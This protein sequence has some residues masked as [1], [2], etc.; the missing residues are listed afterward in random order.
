[1]RRLAAILA[2]GLLACNVQA[3]DSTF[4][5]NGYTYYVW[6]NTVSTN[7]TPTNTTYA[8]IL[9]VAGGG[10]AGSRVASTGGGGAGGVRWTNFSITAGSNYSVTV[11]SGGAGGGADAVARGSNGAA[12]VFGQV[13]STGGGGGG[14]ATATSP[15]FNGQNGGSG[16]GGAAPSGDA[17]SSPGSGSAGQG[18]DG[19]GK[20]FISVDERSGGGGGGAG[21]RGG[22]G[23]RNTPGAGG[24]GLNYSAWL[25]FANLGSNGVFAAGGRGGYY[26][27]N[28]LAVVHGAPGTGNGGLGTANDEAANTRAGGN[29]GSGIVIVKAFPPGAARQLSPGYPTLASVTNST[30]PLTWLAPAEGPTPSNYLVRVGASATNLPLIATTT[31]LTYTLDLLNQSTY[32]QMYWRIDAQA[33]GVTTTGTLASFVDAYQVAS[34]PTK[35]VDKTN[36]TARSPYTSWAAAATSLTQAFGVAESGDTIVVGPGTYGE[37]GGPS[38]SNRYTIPSNLTV[39]SRDGPA[40]TR[41]HGRIYIRPVTT[42]YLA[43]FRFEGIDNSEFRYGIL[44]CNN[45]SSALVV[46]NCWFIANTN[47]ANENGVLIGAIHI[48]ISVTHC[49]SSRNISS[50][51]AS[52]IYSRV[53]ARNCI[54]F[55][56][57]SVI[58]SFSTASNCT[59]VGASASAF[60]STAASASLSIYAGSAANNT[61]T[62][63]MIR[64]AAY[65]TAIG[66]TTNMT[67]TNFPAVPYFSAYDNFD[68]FRPLGNSIIR[69]DGLGALPYKPV[70]TSRTAHRIRTGGTQ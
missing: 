20:S 35:Y 5:T 64:A 63:P 41:I 57:G 17:A 68:A 26:T 67:G 29:G 38:G 44:T 9:V 55:G 42:N 19:G 51:E 39:I 34:G 49:V 40:A 23:S 3:Q 2:I 30:A 16:G 36:T 14:S 28:V 43:G 33:G 13:E 47:S 54:S 46:S 4:E 15:N 62:N 70:P 24:A 12:S 66:W 8:E 21:G 52:V 59:V 53:A 7:W 6:T 10:G 56:D 60:A 11:G 50:G 18:F 48:N 37:W 45:P 61:I 69:K 58:F 27:T 65:L 25:A 22:N 31:N 32:G 1:M